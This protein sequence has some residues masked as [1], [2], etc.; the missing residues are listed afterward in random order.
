MVQT[1]LEPI[2]EG[3][4]FDRHVNNQSHEAVSLPDLSSFAEFAKFKSD[5]E[6][7]LGAPLA[8]EI[9]G[10]THQ[11]SIYHPENLEKTER[12]QALKALSYLR[13]KY[14]NRP[15]KSIGRTGHAKVAFDPQFIKDRIKEAY[16]SEAF[17]LTFQHAIDA[18]KSPHHETQGFR[19]KPDTLEKLSSD[20]GV[21]FTF[22]ED[23]HAFEITLDEAF[24]N[25]GGQELEPTE[26]NKIMGEALKALK[27]A[28]EIPNIS[29]TILN[30]GTDQKEIR[31]LK[32]KYG[33][34]KTEHSTPAKNDIKKTKKPD[35]FKTTIFI[36]DEK[37]PVYSRED[38]KGKKPVIKRG[39]LTPL[40]EKYTV[41]VKIEN[42]ENGD[43]HIR[44]HPKNQNTKPEAIIRAKSALIKLLNTSTVITRQ[45]TLE[46]IDPVASLKREFADHHVAFIETA[47]ASEINSR[48]LESFGQDFAFELVHGEGGYHAFA[49]SEAG[50]KRAETLLSNITPL[51][52]EA[53]TGLVAQGYKDF[54]T[55]MQR[56][57]SQEHSLLSTRQSEVQDQ[58]DV[59]TD[60]IDTKQ[61]EINKRRSVIAQQEKAIENTKSKVKK[62][63][64]HKKIEGAQAK[65]NDLE[66]EIAHLQDR[67]PEAQA[68]LEKAGILTA[69]ALRVMEA[70][71]K[72]DA[73]H[74]AANDIVQNRSADNHT[75]I[76][77]FLT[78]L[79][80]EPNGAIETYIKMLDAQWK[81]RDT[82]KKA[83]ERAQLAFQKVD[84]A[85]KN[86]KKD[87]KQ[88]FIPALNKARKNL[89]AAKKKYKET[90]DDLE[91]LKSY[92]VLAIEA[93][94]K[95]VEEPI[96]FHE[97]LFRTKR[98]IETL[99]DE[100]KAEAQQAERAVKAAETEF[101]ARK[102]K[103]QDPDPWL[104]E[105]Q[106]NRLQ[107]VREEVE[108]L[109][110]ALDSIHSIEEEWRP[111]YIEF[112]AALDKSLTPHRLMTKT[113]ELEANN[114]ELSDVSEKLAME[115]GHTADTSVEKN[116]RI[117]QL[118]ELTSREKKLSSRITTLKKE[119]K[120]LE[121]T[122]A[123]EALPDIE[124]QARRL[125]DHKAALYESV[126]LSLLDTQTPT[127]ITQA[128]PKLDRYT[129]ARQVNGKEI[130]RAHPL[131]DV[132]KAS[133]GI[134]E[135]KISQKREQRTAEIDKELAE[136]KRRAT[137]KRRFEQFKRGKTPETSRILNGIR[138]SGLAAFLG[139]LE[140]KDP[141]YSFQNAMLS[142]TGIVFEPE[143][144]EEE[145]DV[146]GIALYPAKNPK[147]NEI[148][149]PA[150]EKALSQIA[151]SF[152]K[153][154]PPNNFRLSDFIDTF[155]H[156]IQ[157]ISALK[158]FRTDPIQAIDHP[159]AHEF[160][161]TQNREAFL[162]NLERGFDIKI[163]PSAD[164]EKG[165]FDVFVRHS[166]SGLYVHKRMQHIGNIFDAIIRRAK[167]NEI[168]AQ[169]NKNLPSDQHKK[170]YDI[171]RNFINTL[172]DRAKK[173]DL[174]TSQGKLVYDPE[175]AEAISA[176][177]KSLEKRIRAQ[178]Q[179]ELDEERTRLKELTQK[180]ES[181]RTAQ[182]NTVVEEIKTRFERNPLEYYSKAQE[183]HKKALDNN[184]VTIADGP[185]ATGKTY[186][187]VR[188]SIEKF[189][190]G[191][192]DKIIITR[193]AVE[194]GASIGFLPGSIDKKFDPYMRPV[195]DILDEMIGQE[196]RE[197][198][199]KQ[200]HLE[201]G[202]VGHLRGRTLSRSYVI[203][204]ESQNLTKEQTKMVH[205]RLGNGSFMALCGDSRQCD[206]PEQL[207]GHKPHIDMIMEERQKRK[208]AFNQTSM[209]TY[210]KEDA[211]TREPYV[212][213]VVEAQ[214]NH[215]DFSMKTRVVGTMELD[216]FIEKVEIANNKN[217]PDQLDAERIATAAYNSASVKEQ[218]VAQVT[219]LDHFKTRAQRRLR[220]IFSNEAA[221]SSDGE[222]LE[223]LDDALAIAE[224]EFVQITRDMHSESSALREA[225]N[226]VF[227]GL[228]SNADEKRKLEIYRRTR[229]IH[230]E[231]HAEIA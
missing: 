211:K 43:T 60:S 154:E 80:Q 16:H 29:Q 36:E 84:H 217:A 25:T 169:A 123:K 105:R 95:K 131:T 20:M 188:A 28:V 146:W 72:L 106:E 2:T 201:V 42:L 107:S 116:K 76:G 160:F 87:Q 166:E 139:K 34:S 52:L 158:G 231:L 97:S 82:Q 192:I 110:D 143:L 38:E 6:N 69:H 27:L 47:F 119:I 31:R 49:L 75:A 40:G 202:S 14:V 8:F 172:I 218:M 45:T 163:I 222:D 198:L 140:D 155:R 157:A 190:N 174:D 226:T 39:A 89:G 19:P 156:Q 4:E 185:A 57:A 88:T 21:A 64:A 165:R 223:H 54:I 215:P 175:D 99:L 71:E 224:K 144:W 50:I 26:Q 137:N 132:E 22:D 66:K 128:K 63:T 203:V 44:L 81:Q 124:T 136:E 30:K 141:F 53:E 204:D 102:K 109:G 101:E 108:R 213:E 168:N 153:D 127:A 133:W 183:R 91:A 173:G 93:A 37:N 162:E 142:E 220:V 150:I 100:A 113:V 121:E 73:A 125:L 221:K 23:L 164:R 79:S 199:Q 197:I 17:T 225:A 135:K 180:A 227:K 200:G 3:N 18:K 194:A 120:S 62:E 12:Q 65:I 145:N 216:D 55:K 92:P 148:Y 207:S 179:A 90:A 230:N 85:H 187:A 114:R 33:V 229:E 138:I 149:K 181:K 206:I 41:Q 193:P 35:T 122:C 134:V 129:L 96:F 24:W 209:V 186:M 7:E 219:M 126:D 214:E 32:K 77:E 78:N 70:Y 167:R 195:Y 171:D 176:I 51:V 48:L 46:Q 161:T 10:N 67:L 170:I 1:P 9:I 5:I 74:T 103:D 212:Q 83:L 13:D 15:T 111:A 11:I 104:V 59:F 184:R 182:I 210:K 159:E 117:K 56:F 151:L 115:S 94:L 68:P 196:K 130:L 178:I 118:G 189:I 61:R 177:E 147:K 98:Q 58:I 191:E 228:I 208:N 112:L 152:Q 205:T 86:A